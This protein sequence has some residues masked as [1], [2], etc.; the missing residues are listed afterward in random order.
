MSPKKDSRSGTDRTLKVLNSS[1]VNPTIT[2]G[3]RTVELFTDRHAHIRHFLDCVNDPE[4]RKP[5]LFFHGVGG[6]GKSLLL[7][8]LSE[9]YCIYI[10]PENWKWMREKFPRNK[11]IVEESRKALGTKEIPTASVD[12]GMAPQG[13]DHPQEVLSALLMLRRSLGHGTAFLT[14]QSTS[15]SDDPQSNEDVQ[16]GCFIFQL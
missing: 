13:N 10:E 15:P 9:Q 5:I 2:E 1:G 14:P 3:W 8:I 11:G 6:N 4:V 7:R 12:F 16:R